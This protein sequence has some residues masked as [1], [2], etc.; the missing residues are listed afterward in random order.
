MKTY[1]KIREY[2]KLHPN[3]TNRTEIAKALNVSRRAVQ[4]VLNKSNKKQGQVTIEVGQNSGII[5]IT[6]TKIITVEDALNYADIDEEKWEV[7]RVIT[8]HWDVTMKQPDGNHKTVTNYQIKVYLKRKVKL[9]IEKVLTK[10]KNIK[11]IKTIKP[12]K[13]KGDATAFIGL[14]DIHFGKLAWKEETNENIDLKTTR[15]LYL[16]G[17]SD[18]LDRLESFG[19]SKFIYPIGQD[20]L[21]IN[22]A[23]NTTVNDTQQDVDSRLIKVYSTAFET[24][25][26]GIC[27]CLQVAP[28]ELIYLTGNHDRDTSWFLC[29]ALQ[30]Y[31]RTCRHLSVDLKPI[32]RKYRSFGKCLIGMAHATSK[33]ER[34][35]L[36]NLM[37]TEQK[38]NWPKAE[39]CEWLT[40]HLHHSKEERITTVDSDLSQTIRIL[41]SLNGHDKYHFDNAF[42]SPRACE[43]YIYSPY[44]GYIGHISTNP[45]RN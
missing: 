8:N 31:F 42:I 32:C 33:R 18:T 12:K 2:I 43:T 40:G 13:L 24:A 3:E 41:P 16:N 21:H 4:H 35:K 22:S 14:Y 20:F 39:C 9:V 38:D 37:P 30:Q 6:D 7:D 17:I 29:H 26:Q 28:V 19:I 23:N 11:P 45:R 10:I 27:M 1:E 25:M 34:G 5:N 36:H 44:D 15:A